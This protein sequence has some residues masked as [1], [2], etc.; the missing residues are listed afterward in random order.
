MASLAAHSSPGQNGWR[1]LSGSWMDRILLLLALLGIALS[2]QWIHARVASGPPMA[3]VYHGE[4]LLAR[5]PMPPAEPIHLAVEGTIGTSEIIID[6]NGVRFAS[7]PCSSQQC[8]LSGY[9]HH[10]GDTA[11]CVPNQ[12]MITIRG[13]QQ[14]ALDGISR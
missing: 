13:R 2:W 10:A 9:H 8:V 3:L 4:E 5:Y 14:D 11:A 12:I 6:Q 7:S 1:W